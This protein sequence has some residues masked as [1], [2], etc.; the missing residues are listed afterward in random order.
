MMKP[1]K[2]I[3]SL[4]IMLTPSLCRASDA[5]R[6]FAVWPTTDD[7]E[8]PAENSTGPQLYDGATLKRLRLRRRMD[9]ERIEEITKIRAPQIVALEESDYPS[10][11][12]SV[13]LR[14]F[15]RAYAICLDLDPDKVVNDYMDGY[16]A[17]R[18]MRV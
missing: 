11:P 1:L 2:Y 16:D 4:L 18:R 5:W 7:Q 14:G 9:V 15:L 12:P 8:M 10:L 17:W 3:L 13:F 6:E